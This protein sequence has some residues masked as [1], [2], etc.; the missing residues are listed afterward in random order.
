LDCLAN[1]IKLSMSPQRSKRLA[2]TRDNVSRLIHGAEALLKG[3]R[4]F[5]LLAG[6]NSPPKVKRL[7][8]ELPQLNNRFELLK[9]TI[10]SHSKSIILPIQASEDG[11]LSRGMFRSWM[12]GCHQLQSCLQALNPER[13]EKVQ[14]VHELI[15]AL[16]QRFVEAL[17]PITLASRQGRIFTKKDITYVDCTTPGVLGEKS[18]LLRPS[19]KEY[20]EDL[21]L[22]GIVISMDEA[23]IV[24]LNLGS[25]VGLIE[26]LEHAEGGKGRTLRLTFSDKFDRPGDDGKSGKLRRMWF[27]GQLLKEIKLDKNTDNMKLGCNAV[28]GEMT[29]ECSRMTSPKIMQDAFEKLIKVL[30]AMY[31]LDR[32][33]GNKPIFEGGQWDFNLLA[34]RL[35]RDVATEADRFAFQ[36][37]L[38]L[39]SYRS[40]GG[41]YT[42]AACRSLLSKHHQQ[43]VRHARRLGECQ[44]S[45][46]LREKPEDSLREMLMSDAISEDTR[47]ELLHHFL[48]LNPKSATRLVE[49]VYG[50]GNQCFVINP[51]YR[52]RL[53]FYAP[54]GPSFGDHKE[55][56]MNALRKHGL[57]YAS[58]RVRN[59]KDFVLHAI[60][61]HP[62]ELQYLS[63]K[64]RDNRDIVVAA[65]EKYPW[66]LRYASERL[67]TDKDII[68]MAIADSIDTLSFASE[69]V[70]SDREYMLDL[71]AKNARAFIYVASGL[72]D[73]TAFIEAAKQRNPEVLEYAASSANK[74]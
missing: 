49:Q 21:G 73:D 7:L 16:H 30:R 19:G 26:L 29:V 5:L 63:E 70:L 3:Y 67:R 69:K 62:L 51:S 56:V 35:N 34:Q 24:N 14:S 17:A 65:V 36:H 8:K 55:K 18:P 45:V 33:F 6:D 4:A 15:F 39:M 52:Y 13:A 23:S 28:A 12:A 66:A 54:P 71:I 20:M 40:G 9:K 47:R 11:L 48:L 59:D 43:F 53:E 64:L 61:E 22:S 50:L 42:S 68:R 27:L 37:C 72:K 10:R 31:N 58:Q 46:F 44:W 32:Q 57:E 38:F 41:W 74:V 1:P 25:H 60:S 2:E